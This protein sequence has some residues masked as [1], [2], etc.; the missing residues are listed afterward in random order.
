MFCN[1]G[2]EVTVGESILTD[3]HIRCEICT[4]GAKLLA[5]ETPEA[6]LFV[7]RL[8]ATNVVVSLGGSSLTEQVTSHFC[9]SNDQRE[10]AEVAITDCTE[11]EN[12]MKT[13]LKTLIGAGAA[14]AMVATLQLMPTNVALAYSPSLDGVAVCQDNGSIKVT[15]TFVSDTN[16]PLVNIVSPAAIAANGVST[17]TNSAPTSRSYIEVYPAG[18]ATASTA[19]TVQYFFDPPGGFPIQTNTKTATIALPATCLRPPPAG[20]EWCSPGY[21]RQPHHLDSWAATG[22]STG[23][24]YNSFGFSPQL[25][26]NPT[27]LQVLQSPQTYNKKGSGAFN[28]VGD[29]LS[30]AHPDVDFDGKRVENCPL[31]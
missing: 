25:T 6:Y 14:L 17:T 30:G 7:W 18:M 29:L 12:N 20:G 9:R 28:N 8:C 22:I 27:L 15:W 1:G 3:G 23:A 24:F 4:N 31:N 19:V 5:P 11:M 13:K 26:G 2:R 21:W 10:R 16:V